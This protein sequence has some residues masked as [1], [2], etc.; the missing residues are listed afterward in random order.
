MHSK[1]YPYVNLPAAYFG[2]TGGIASGKSTVAHMFEELGAKIIDA[3]RIGHEMLQPSEPTH[4]LIVQQLGKDVLDGGGN[5]DRRKLG[6]LVFNDP[7]RLAQLDAIVHPAII[8]RVGERARQLAVED[9]Q[10]LVIVDAALIYETGIGGNFRKIIVAWCRPEQQV[11]R[12]I[13]KT[14]MP[15]HEAEQRIAAQMPVEEKRR[16]ADYVIDCSGPK[17]HTREQVE[18]IYPQLRSLTGNPQGGNA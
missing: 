11:E 14:G 12:L 3:D 2:L 1:G 9:P 8:A 15:R 7:A 13:G 18:R 5:I 16:R 6:A 17:E 10:A 4:A